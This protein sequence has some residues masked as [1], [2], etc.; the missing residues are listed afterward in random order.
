MLNIDEYD[1]VI[2]DCDGVILDSNLIKTEAFRQTLD[3]YPKEKIEV[4]IEYHKENA[5]ISRQVK[6]KYFFDMIVQEKCSNIYNKALV[7]FGDICAESLRAS[8]LIPGVVSFLD[9]LYKKD[10]PTYVVSGGSEIEIKDVFQRKGIYKYFKSIH[11]NP[12]SKRD[13]LRYLNDSGSLRGRGLYF[14]DAELDWELANE[15]GLNFVFIAGAS[16]W[17]NGEKYCLDNELDFFD[18][19][20]KLL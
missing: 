16:E 7:D 12:T 2:F 6:F 20:S 13:S 14:G 19:F 3:F 8:P 11:G 15:F 17:E 9:F 1:Y 10:I 18:D 4:F 5:G